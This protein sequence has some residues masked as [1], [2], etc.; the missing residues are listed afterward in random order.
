VGR[1]SRRRGLVLRLEGVE[2][3]FFKLLQVEQAWWVPRVTRINSSSLSWMA[4]VSRFCVFWIKKTQEGDD[5]GAGVDD[6]LP[7]VSLKPNSGPVT[8]HNR[9]PGLPC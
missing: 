3:L 4:S 5:R 7:G 1:A 2:R 9:M 8:S 6:Q